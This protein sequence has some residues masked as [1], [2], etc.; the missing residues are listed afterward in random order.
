MDNFDGIVLLRGNGQ[1]PMCFDDLMNGDEFGRDCGGT[2]YSFEP[3][4]SCEP[5]T[6]L[7]EILQDNE[8]GGE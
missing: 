5:C 8:D 6:C 3:P 7:D 2:G 1:C 4:K